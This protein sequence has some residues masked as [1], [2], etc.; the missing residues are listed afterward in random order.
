MDVDLS[1]P[2]IGAALNSLIREAFPTKTI[3]DPA[4]LVLKNKEMKARVVGKTVQPS[5]SASDQSTKKSKPN[6][7][8]ASDSIDSHPHSSSGTN[9]MTPDKNKVSCF[10]SKFPVNSAH[11]ST[12]SSITI[13]AT[14]S[15]SGS[16][17]SLSEEILGNRYSENNQGPFCVHIQRLSNL[18]AQLHP[19]SV[20]KVI[21]MLMREVILEVKKVGFCKVAVFMKTWNA[22]NSLIDNPQ[23][24]FNDFVAFI[25]PFCTSRK[26][27]IRDVP[28]E[29]TEEEI[30]SGSNSPFKILSARR[31]NRSHFTYWKFGYRSY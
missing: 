11:F 9:Y 22:A 12:S 18:N 10:S 3:L 8:T 5:L 7:K 29:I 6:K 25:P 16:V 23:L 13:S 15:A 2:D 1:P 30:I 28:I 21:H 19:I 26:D 4:K 20:G 24:K 14:G 31:F 17:I 27:I